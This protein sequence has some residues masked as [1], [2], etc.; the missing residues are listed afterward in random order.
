MKKMKPL[1]TNNILI[2]IVVLLLVVIGIQLFANNNVLRD[3]EAS[4]ELTK[5]ELAR[6]LSPMKD[7]E[8]EKA[9][10][11]M[12][13]E[14]QAAISED[15]AQMREKIKANDKAYSLL[16]DSVEIAEFKIRCKENVVLWKEE[17][18]CD[19]ES[20]YSDYPPINSPL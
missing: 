16:G 2:G 14:K 11:I 8:A 13:K 12:E 10:R 15:T 9:I 6:T 18:V 3:K 19:D 20:V 17:R 7:L 1:E 4:L 5:N